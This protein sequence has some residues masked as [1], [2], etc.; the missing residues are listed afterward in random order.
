MYF[1]MTRLLTAATFLAVASASTPDNVSSRLMVHIPHSLFKEEGYDHREALFGVPPY[2]GSIATNVYYADDEL[3]DSDVDTH[4]GYPSRETGKNG[5]M[6][7]WPSPFILMVDRG[8]CT[9]VKK[10]RN[11]QRAGAAGV[12]IADNTCLCSD[13]K[14]IEESGLQICETSEPIMADDGSGSDISIPSFLMF[15]VDADAIKKELKNDKPVQLEMAW[16]L[17][18]PDDRV[19]YDLWTVPTDSVS[20]DFLENFKDVAVALG[21]SAYFTPHMYIYDGVRSHCQGS[22]GQN[23]CYSLCTNNGRYC[24]TDP[25]NDLEKGIS[26]SDVVKESLRRL[27]IWKHYGDVDGVGSV[28]WDYVVEFMSRCNNP[29]YFMNEDCVKDVYKHSKVD[30]AAIDRCMKDSGGLTSDTTNAFLELEI[31]AQTERGVVVLPTAFVN[32]AAIRGALTVNNVFDAICAGFAEGTSPKICRQCQKCGD[33]GECAKS[34]GVCKTGS[35]SGGV[36]QTTFLF[37]IVII[38]G[39]FGGAYFWQYKKNKEDMRDQVRGILAEYMPLEDQD[40][41][42]GSPMDFARQGGTASLI[43]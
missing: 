8:G 32:T 22:D 7:P 36:S 24:A 21:Q 41:N 14:C 13:T 40:E 1:D 31:S 25:D 12:I 33:P 38:T 3:C 9:F 39:L 30:G 4:K 23:M 11:A 16:S 29:D 5:K 19:E 20:R 43:K 18:T 6:E 34:K 28:W 2:G 27:C 17:P 35:I 37:W 26:G 42:G 15:K 10:V